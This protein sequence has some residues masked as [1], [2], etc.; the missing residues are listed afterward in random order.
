[1]KWKHF[2]FLFFLFSYHLF[3]LTNNNI[4][5]KD[6]ISF[7]S[8]L[9]Y[10]PK[11]PNSLTKAFIFFNKKK[12]ESLLLKDTLSTIRHLR[13]IAS[14]EFKLG[15]YYGSEITLV[16][17]INLLDHLKVNEFAN[18]I[19]VHI[20]NQLGR[21]NKELLNYEL[22]LNYYDKALSFAKKRINIVIINNNIALVYRDQKNLSLIHI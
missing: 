4:Q 8:N 13:Q 14:I 15:D 22:S 20:Y 17:A 12:E 9:A 1:M 21:T 3:C 11:D 2:S 6:S 7:Y 10:Y 18:N 5:E 19:K 16:E